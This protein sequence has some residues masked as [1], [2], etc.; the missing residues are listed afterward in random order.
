M[1][2]WLIAGNSWRGKPVIVPDRHGT[3][4]W[5]ARRLQNARIESRKGVA[6][7]RIAIRFLAAIVNTN[8]HAFRSP[9]RWFTAGETSANANPLACGVRVRGPSPNATRP[10]M[11]FITHPL[12]SVSDPAFWSGLASIILIDL[13]LAGDNAIVIALA[14]RSLPHRLQM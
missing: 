1:S 2:C 3:L 8:A 12:T 5:L 13:V 10:P 11:E 14:A 4:T 6:R 9:R 7:A